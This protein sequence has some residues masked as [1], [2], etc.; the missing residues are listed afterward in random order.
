MQYLLNFSIKITS[1]PICTGHISNQLQC[2]E[3]LFKLEQGEKFNHAASSSL[4]SEDFT[5]EASGPVLPIDNV[6]ASSQMTSH[7]SL[8]Q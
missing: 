4:A 8:L 6:R 2:V 7:V 5:S 3:E 1:L